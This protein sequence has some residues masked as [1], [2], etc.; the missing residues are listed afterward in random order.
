M[1]DGA[2]PTRQSGR[3]TTR[4][5]G[6]RRRS[7]KGDGW[8]VLA[9]FSFLARRRDVRRSRADA[10]RQTW[11]LE[12]VMGR[13]R[14]STRERHFFP[15]YTHMECLLLLL[16]TRGSIRK[17]RGGPLV[18]LPARLATCCCSRL[19]RLPCLLFFPLLLSLFPSSCPV[20]FV[21]AREQTKSTHTPLRKRLA[22]H[23]AGKG[24]WC[25]L[26]G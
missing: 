17:G 24:V 22:T 14:P 25:T 20:H 18:G 21:C 7:T 23:V 8:V 12:G 4:W 5:V 3:L 10:R 26:S 13:R 15:T 9:C 6:C 11:G 1:F 16:R 2:E 19:S